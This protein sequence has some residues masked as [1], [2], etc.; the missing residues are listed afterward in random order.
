MLH[1][2]YIS[3][4]I[5]RYKVLIY[6]EIEKKSNSNKRNKIIL[7]LLIKMTTIQCFILS[8]ACLTVGSDAKFFNRGCW[9]GGN[10][11]EAGK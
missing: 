11:G 10:G 4:N 1:R 5:L 8:S 7:I 9:G 6:L 3:R 2:R